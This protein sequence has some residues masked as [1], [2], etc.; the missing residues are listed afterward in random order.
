MVKN[1]FMLYVKQKML[2]IKC[3]MFHKSTGQLI[4]IEWGAL[5]L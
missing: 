3:K 1:S 5:G 2:H 4:L